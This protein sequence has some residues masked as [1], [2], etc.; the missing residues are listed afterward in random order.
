MPKLVDTLDKLPQDVEVHVHIRDLG[1]ID[2]ACME[3]ISTWE[4]QRND[5][6][7]STVV[8]WDELMSKYRTPNRERLGEA[9]MVAAEAAR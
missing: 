1:Y 2:H 3:A 5:R 9:E 6:A 8:E 4:K 7:S